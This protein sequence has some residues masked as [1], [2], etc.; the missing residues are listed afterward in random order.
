M[1]LEAKR[2]LKRY[3]P[4]RLEDDGAFVM[5]EEKEKVTNKPIGREIRAIT[6]T[7]DH[8]D[9]VYLSQEGY[10]HGLSLIS[11]IALPSVSSPPGYPSVTEWGEH[12]A[13]LDDQEVYGR[14]SPGY[15]KDKVDFD[16]L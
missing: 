3:L 6:R 11:D 9:R 7:Y 16:P 2:S 15:I 5:S 14:Q 8:P 12:S 10:D 13:A 4:A 1:V